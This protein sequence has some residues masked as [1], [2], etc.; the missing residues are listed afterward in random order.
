MS[1]LTIGDAYTFTVSASIPAATA[2]TSAISPD[3][4]A[5]LNV[6]LN[7]TNPSSAPDQAQGDVYLLSNGTQVGDVVVDTWGQTGTENVGFDLPAGSVLTV[8]WSGQWWGFPG[9]G[10]LTTL[11]ASGA[12]TGTAPD[13]TCQPLVNG[14]Q[15][16]TFTMS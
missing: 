7:I 9:T 6:T 2:V 1:G 10:I 16:V 14:S 5:H 12:C 4:G 13:I 15:H 11:T 8:N 3:N